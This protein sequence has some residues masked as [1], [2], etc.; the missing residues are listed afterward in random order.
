[1]VEAA[2]TLNFQNLERAASATAERQTFVLALLGNLSFAWSNNESLLIHLIQALVPTDEASAV[3]I[4]STLTTARARVELVERLGR[5]KIRDDALRRDLE[6]LLSRFNDLTKVR[7]EFIHCMY[8]VD[9]KGELSHT[10]SFRI[11]NINGRQSLERPQAIDNK[12]IRAL[13]TAIDEMKSLNRDLWAILPKLRA[14]VC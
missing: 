2:N 1:M 10:Q 11:R 9:E 12:R 8:G 5:T 14:H 13:L 6:L 7:N 3:I 4:F